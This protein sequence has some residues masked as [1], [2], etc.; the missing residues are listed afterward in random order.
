MTLT[1]VNE[2]PLCPCAGPRAQ[3]CSTACKHACL[4]CSWLH[5][6]RSRL[7]PQRLSGDTSMSGDGLQS[8]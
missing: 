7:S 6:V 4:R 3:H 8:P 1:L 2:M 5:Q